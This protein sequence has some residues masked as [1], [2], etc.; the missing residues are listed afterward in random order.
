[1]K[2]SIPLWSLATGASTCSA[3]CNQLPAPPRPLQDRASNTRPG[4]LDPNKNMQIPHIKESELNP[5]P[6][7][8]FDQHFRTNTP[9]LFGIGPCECRSDSI[10]LPK[11]HFPLLPMWRRDQRQPGAAVVVISRKC[12]LM[13]E[14]FLLITAVSPSRHRRVTRRCRFPPGC[15]CLKNPSFLSGIFSSGMRALLSWLHH[16]LPH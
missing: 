2:R 6:S 4:T 12:R 3:S 10:L 7:D 14:W 11:L 5:E 15:C 9:R 8:S 13:K 16:T 1:M